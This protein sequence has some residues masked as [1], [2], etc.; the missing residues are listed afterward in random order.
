MKIKSFP[1]FNKGAY[2]G[3]IITEQRTIREHPIGL[4]AE[5]TIGYERIKPDGKP[6]GK[7]IEWAF[8]NYLNGKDG[9]RLKQKMAKGQWKPIRDV[10]EVEPQDGYDVLF[11]LWMF[12][13]KIL[14]IMLC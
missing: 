4:V 11:R 7:G 9:K 14:P 8:R 10:N 5:R 3:G 2:K 12:I 13:F 6:D 1:L